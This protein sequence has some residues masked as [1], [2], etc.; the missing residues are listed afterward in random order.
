LL[1][2]TMIEMISSNLLRN[3]CQ[4]INGSHLNTFSQQMNTLPYAPRGRKITPSAMEK[5]SKTP[6]ARCGETDFRQV[7]LYCVA[8]AAATAGVVLG[9]ELSANFSNTGPKIMMH[10]ICAWRSIRCWESRN[11][12]NLLTRVTRTGM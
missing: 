3:V 4:N 8:A 9:V 10:G 11:N 2:P 7:E 12:I 1:H 6:Y 5:E